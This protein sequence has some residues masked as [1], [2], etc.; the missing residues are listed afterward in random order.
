MIRKCVFALVALVNLCAALIPHGNTT[1]E[2]ATV[3]VWGEWAEDV[4]ADY[5]L[6]GVEAAAAWVW[7]NYWLVAGAIAGLWL[8]RW[9]QSSLIFEGG[10]QGTG[11]QHIR[12]ELA[13]DMLPPYPNGWYKILDSK[14]LTPGKVKSVQVCGKQ[15]VAFRTKEGKLGILD[16][17]CPHL[18]ANLAVHG[19]VVDNCVVCPFHAWRFNTE[20][21][22]EGIEYSDSIPKGSNIT[23]YPSFEALNLIY[24][25]YDVEC[26]EPA[27]FPVEDE[28][29]A[30]G[31]WKH[32]AWSGHEILSHICEI[33]ENGA[34]SAHLNVVHKAFVFT[35]R[36]IPEEKSFFEHEWKA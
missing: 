1:F 23:S 15:L 9:N 27:W 10:W 36:E 16:A 5:V 29:V 13:P 3:N 12:K 28:N 17:Y 34:D 22:C 35:N 32:L 24:V 30:S 18:G 11:R 20:G 2:E 14:D 33:P 6:P 7:E 8:F 19:K 31:K 4:A 25:W 26:R 21:D